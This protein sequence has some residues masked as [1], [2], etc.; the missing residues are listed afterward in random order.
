MR[1]TAVVP[2]AGAGLRFIKKKG[3]RKPFFLLGGKPILIHTLLALEASSHIDDII[4]VAHKDDILRCRA[5]AQKFKIKKVRKIIAGGRTR[6][7][8][9][10]NGLR[11]MDKNTRIVFIHDGVRPLINEEIISNSVKAC[12]KHGAAVC[13]VPAI[14]TIKNVGKGMVISQT[15]ERS[16]LYIAQ[17]PQVFKRAIIEKAYKNHVPPPGWAKKITD[18][19]MLVERLKCKVKIVKGSYNNIK[20]TTPQDLILAKE[21]LKR[22]T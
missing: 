7:E 8:S 18:D 14:S 4:V 17:T 19:S 10:R 21:L 5:A 15:P 13:G 16:S 20:V 11:A 9:V 22:R 12:L 1:T 6:F 3:Q 2:A